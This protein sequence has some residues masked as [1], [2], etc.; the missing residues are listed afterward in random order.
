[1]TER[2]FTLGLLGVCALVMLTGCGTG[3]QYWELS[4]YGDVKTVD[5][6]Q[7][8]DGRV[9]LHGK[10]GG[11][12]VRDVRVVFVGTDNTTIKSVPIGDLDGTHRRENLTVRLNQTPQSIRVI[13]DRVK[14][15]ENAR[16]AFT[17]LTLTE[18]GDYRQY[19]QNTTG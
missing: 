12:T 8:F 2:R 14:S 15:P 4:V 19:D 11:V 3:G 10:T 16:H 9:E 18:S 7:T 13:A 17:G 1:M 6:E 5:G